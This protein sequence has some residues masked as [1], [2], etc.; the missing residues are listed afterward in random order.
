MGQNSYLPLIKSSFTHNSY[1]RLLESNSMPVRKVTKFEY[2]TKQDVINAALYF[3][4]E[5]TATGKQILSPDMIIDFLNLKLAKLEH[6]VF[7]CVFL[8]N[9]NKV[10]KFKKMFR[11]TIDGTVV[12]TR[13]V[14]KEALK[15][16]AAAVIFAHN[17]PSGD[18]SPSMEDKQITK[19]LVDALSLVDIKVLDHFV[20]GKETVSFVKEGLID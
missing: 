19:R 8:N 5:D 3:I 12:Y 20:I 18:P 15:L 17:H 16:N 9:K 14:V 13:E 1:L 6:E 4:S 2:K 7:C 11:G 10:I